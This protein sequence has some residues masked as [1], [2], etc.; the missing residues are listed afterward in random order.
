MVQSLTFFHDAGSTCNFFS[1]EH[2]SKQKSFID[3]SLQYERVFL[4]F[5]VCSH[6]MFFLEALNH[7]PSFN[8]VS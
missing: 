3:G 1:G 8:F 2:L 4:K 6:P 5:K 7:K